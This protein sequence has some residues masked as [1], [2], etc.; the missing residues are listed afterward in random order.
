MINDNSLTTDTFF[1]GRIRVK[2]NRSG[3]RF[4]I[5]AVLLASHANPHPGDTILDLGTGC[6]IIPLILTQHNPNIKV[7]GIEVQEEL[8]KIAAVN[9]KENRREDQIT[10]L[11][12]DMKDL[13]YDMISG[14]ADLVVSNPPYRPVGAGR[15]NPDR[16]RAIAR[17][18]IRTTLYDVVETARRMLH[19]SGR[20]ISIYPAERMTDIFAQMR[21]ASIEPKFLRMIHSGWDTAAKLVLVEGVKGGRAGIKIGAPLIIYSK[22]GS[23]TDEVKKL[24]GVAIEKS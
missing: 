1:N 14:P 13:K 19:V 17:H 20:F 9:V 23:Y 4:S 11:C 15:I 2:Q 8:A 10:I 18:E 12:R 6:G 7:Y 5:D 24:C 21:L 16:Q 22:D 3:Y